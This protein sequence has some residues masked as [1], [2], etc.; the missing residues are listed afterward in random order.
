MVTIPLQKPLARS[1]AQR[2][3]ELCDDPLVGGIVLVA[4][5]TSIGPAI[6]LSIFQGSP[7]SF[8]EALG[9]LTEGYVSGKSAVEVARSI[10]EKL[11]ALKDSEPP[12]RSNPSEN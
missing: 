7:E 5:D 3:L 10:L 4:G 11:K 9:L 8:C 1:L 12:S 6:S 2:L